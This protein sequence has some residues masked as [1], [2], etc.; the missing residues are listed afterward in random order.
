MTA[1]CNRPGARL[2][3]LS[4]VVL[5]AALVAVVPDAVAQGSTES[6]RAALEALYDLTGGSSWTDTTNWKT[7]A[8]LDEWYG[9]TTDYEGQ[10]L[11]VWSLNLDRNGR[12]GAGQTI[13]TEGHS[14]QPPR[15][16]DTP[17]W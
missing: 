5:V 7:A 14:T 10:V 12:D 4:A 15:G 11:R 3:A 1:D 6:D 17:I 8:P 9:V 2:T 16:C 13:A